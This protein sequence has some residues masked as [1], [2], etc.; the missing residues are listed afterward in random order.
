MKA[1]KLEDFEK[2]PHAIKELLKRHGIPLSTV[3][4]Y[5]GVSYQYTC[6]LING[7]YRC[8]QH[9]EMKLAAL[10]KYLQGREVPK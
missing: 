5:L 7:T 10:A 2:Q 8:P 1:I 6:N 9:H 4:N 3:A